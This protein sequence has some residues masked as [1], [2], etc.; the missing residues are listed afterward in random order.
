[1]LADDTELGVP[2]LVQLTQHIYLAALKAFESLVLYSNVRHDPS[3]HY[4]TGAIRRRS[5]ESSLDLKSISLP[6]VVSDDHPDPISN[7]LQLS[8][9]DSQ[10][11]EVIIH[12]NLNQLPWNRFAVIPARPL[13]A[14]IDIIIKSEFWNQKQGYPIVAHLID[15]FKHCHQL[16][17]E[18]EI[19]S[20]IKDTKSI[21]VHLIL[22]LHGHDCISHDILPLADAIRN[23]F[24][25]PHT[26]VLIPTCN[27]GKT[28]DGLMSGSLRLMN[29]M[30]EVLS[31][32][33][34]TQISIVAESIGGL[35]ARCLLGLL[36]QS[37]LL[38]DNMELCNFIT[39]D[40]P[41]LGTRKT[42]NEWYSSKYLKSMMSKTGAEL[43]LLDDTP[44]LVTLTT[45][46][47]LRVLSMFKRRILYANVLQDSV[48]YYTSSSITC[49]ASPYMECAANGID[50]IIEIK[51]TEASVNNSI[52]STLLNTFNTLEWTRYAIIPG[53]KGI[54]K[55]SYWTFDQEHPLI[56]HLLQNL[57]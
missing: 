56:S 12:A 4:S 36:F 29:Y 9:Q 38:A 51:A 33:S 5:F 49:S 2:L 8:S 43:N 39:I 31:Q 28:D 13:L 23:Q 42:L 57:E 15:N 24:G 54:Q 26:I 32:Y 25:K 44:I 16:S 48:S 30:K 45:N 7:C 21:N 27:D 37:G 53:K 1:M 50:R 14:H 47:Y 20:S 35:Y 34:I 18:K 6:A 22:I 52:E 55:S 3:V 17:S 40:C 10:N 46:D 19:V 41:H 11:H